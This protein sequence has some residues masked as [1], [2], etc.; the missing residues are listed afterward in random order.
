MIVFPLTWRWRVR[1]SGE[2]RD[3][4]SPPSRRNWTAVRDWSPLPPQVQRFTSAHTAVGA[5]CQF[6]QAEDGPSCISM[7]SYRFMNTV[8]WTVM[9]HRWAAEGKHQFLSLV[10][11]RLNERPLLWCTVTG[12]GLCMF[13]CQII[14]FHVFFFNIAI[15]KTEQIQRPG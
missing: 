8:T 3:L 14:L 15:R 13:V 2:S 10:F 12:G 6:R 4:G 9:I 1:G 7:L 11:T 5:K